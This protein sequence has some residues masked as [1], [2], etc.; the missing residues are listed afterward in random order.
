[1]HH[2]VVM[3]IKNVNISKYLAWVTSA[4]GILLING[5]NES[6]KIE[7]YIMSASMGF[8]SLPI[9]WFEFIKFHIPL[10]TILLTFHLFDWF[11][12][13]D[14]LDECD[15][16][17]EFLEVTIMLPVSMKFIFIQFFSSE[18]PF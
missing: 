12:R 17:I 16:H 14:R 7:I 3:L 11:I 18:N 15:I 4:Y 1:M 8:S 5:G 9:I 10:S 2:K 6:S 13:N